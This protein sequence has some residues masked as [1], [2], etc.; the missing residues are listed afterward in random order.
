MTPYSASEVQGDEME[1]GESNQNDRTNIK[2]SD[3]EDKGS[4]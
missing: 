3:A 2:S 4:T 1:G